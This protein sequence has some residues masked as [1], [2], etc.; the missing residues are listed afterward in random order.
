M[1]SDFDVVMTDYFQFCMVSLIWFISIPVGCFLVG[2]FFKD[3]TRY[4]LI[5]CLV[6]SLVFIVFAIFLSAITIFNV[7][8]NGK[9]TMVR[10][11]HG[12][13]IGVY[14]LCLFLNSCYHSRYAKKDLLRT[15][16]E[17][18]DS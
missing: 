3:A 18:L 14:V 17:E 5:P 6:T 16:E 7:L 10:G 8:L 9:S 12:A 15:E 2:T 11:M 1:F 4:A 13:N